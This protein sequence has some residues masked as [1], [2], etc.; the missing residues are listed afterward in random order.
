MKTK[1]FFPSALTVRVVALLAALGTLMWTANTQAAGKK[2]GGGG[3]TTDGPVGTHVCVTFLDRPTD[4]IQSDQGDGNTP[5][6]DDGKDGKLEVG[7]AVSGSGDF[8][9]TTMY[10]RNPR[11]IFLDFS[12][13][14]GG[15]NSWPW[16]PKLI[17]AVRL[18]YHGAITEDALPLW[19]I[20]KGETRAHGM[21][22]WI[23]DGIDDWRLDYGVQDSFEEDPNGNDPNLL[24]VTRLTDKAQGDSFDSWR[25][26][27]PSTPVIAL[28]GSGNPAIAGHLARLTRIEHLGSHTLDLTTTGFYHVSFAIV[29][30]DEGF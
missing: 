10:A 19:S 16:S 12:D 13:F 22:V 8:I 29:I 7:T 3:D 21:M 23:N 1:L 2:G 15:A 18:D 26:E 4:G 14:V 17:Y 5:Y 27:A 25:I 9:L 24:L 6:C 20:E 11:G 28:D 30:S